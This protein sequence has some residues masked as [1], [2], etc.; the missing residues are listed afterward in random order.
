MADF[1]KVVKTNNAVCATSTFSKEALPAPDP[2][3][4]AMA[5]LTSSDQFFSVA[6]PTLDSAGRFEAETTGGIKMSITL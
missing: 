3:S 4:Q 2:R 6:S 1:F 5:D